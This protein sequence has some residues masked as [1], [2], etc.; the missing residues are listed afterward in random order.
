MVAFQAAQNFNLI[1]LLLLFYMRG[2]FY[3]I[4]AIFITIPIVIFISL[5]V[6][7]QGG[8]SGIYENIVSDQIH[9]VERSVE[10]DFGKA[11]VTSGK[12]AMIASD[13]YVVMNGV[14]IGDAVSGVKELMQNGTIYGNE[15]LLMVNNT[16]SNWTA[17]II[18]VPVNFDVAISFSDLDVAGN[19]SFYIRASARINVSVA[20]ELGIARIDK[21]NRYYETLIPVEGA[22]DSIFTLKTNGII[23]RIIR[24][25]P[26]PYRANKLVSGGANS[27]G[28]CSGNITF[29]K[30]ECG[31][32]ILVAENISG[33]NFGCFSG[34]II[35]QSANLSANSNCYVTGNS[36]ALEAINQSVADT[37]YMKVYIDSVTK[38]VWHLPIREEIDNKYYFS[39]NGPAF[40]KRLEG[41]LNSTASNGMESF[42]NL[43]ELESYEIPIKQNVISVD[44][45]Y[46]R[47]QDYIGYPVRG[48]QG[49]FRLNSTFAE[50][51]GL[52]ELCSGC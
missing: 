42:V 44:Y 43:P 6:A 38:A 1:K 48:L 17:K 41:D 49:W 8:E 24:I 47:G 27:T 15:S 5:Y 18:A 25:S 51:Y 22:E 26:Y 52:T 31:S 4:I 28:N 16:L 35:E 21:E 46:F 34:F 7:S 13:D 12:R 37:G 33:V 40:L 30:T 23:T 19:S 2:Q 9:Q 32:H 50:K 39:G 45:I 10:T 29:N 3:S 14:P 20:D 36:S 11:L